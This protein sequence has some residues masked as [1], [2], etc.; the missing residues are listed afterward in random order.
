MHN[1]VE[2]RSPFVDH[3]LVEYCIGK[4]LDFLEGKSKI[5]LKEYLNPDFSIQFTERPKMGFVFN[6]ESWIYENLENISDQINDG[7]ISEMFNMSNFRSI[8]HRKSRINAQRI[9]KLLTL[10]NFLQDI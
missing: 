8:N 7:K 10:E 3:R 9:W 6:L 5:I 1:S 2:A 4:N